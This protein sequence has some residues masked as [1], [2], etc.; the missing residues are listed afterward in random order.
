MKRVAGLLGALSVMI[1]AWGQASGTSFGI[2][3]YNPRHA[4]AFSFSSHPASGAQLKNTQAGIYGGR[5]FLLRE[6]NDFQAAMALVTPAGNFGLQLNQYGFDGYRET[7]VGLVHARK[8]G[9]KLDVGI[10]FIYNNINIGAYGS[11]SVISAAGGVNFHITDK[12]HTGLHV[13]NAYGPAI[14]KLDKLPV[15][16][17]MGVGYEA[18]ELF[19][20]S[21]EVVK[22]EDQPVN[23]NIG[24]HY[25]LLPSLHLRAGIATVT[26]S[27]WISAGYS[28][29][30]MRVEIINSF[31][32]L[33]GITPGLMIVFTR[34]SKKEK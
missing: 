32:P 25:Q 27:V 33:L 30:K 26:S 23:I 14:T 31:H 9:S 7:R 29:R 34:E 24:L 20:I 10:G 1:H 13:T 3:S 11:A 2:G 6:L 8:L 21:S 12:L 19:F 22:K 4:D 16:I 17:S 18:S 5:R 15:I 28:Y